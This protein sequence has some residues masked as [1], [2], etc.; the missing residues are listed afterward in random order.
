MADDERPD[1]P[2]LTLGSTAPL[3]KDALEQTHDPVEYRRR[4]VVGQLGRIPARLI[5][6]A[7][8]LAEARRAQP[9]SE[10]HLVYG[11]LEQS[12]SLVA[13]LTELTVQVSAIQDYVGERLSSD[14][15]PSIDVV[16]QADGRREI[17][18][19]GMLDAIEGRATMLAATPAGHP[20]DAIDVFVAALFDPKSLTTY[21]TAAVAGVDRQLLLEG[22]RQRLS[23]Y[24][25]VT[26]PPA[27]IVDFEPPTRI[28]WSKRDEV[29][30][31]LP[32]AATADAYWTY[33]KHE[34]EMLVYAESDA[35]LNV[36]R[37]EGLIDD[38]TAE[39]PTA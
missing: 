17:Y 9:V 24:E 2:P 5:L 29:V 36:L 11:A 21:A 1:Q 3:T 12:D 39:K 34:D 26:F 13:L 38:A 20:V 14:A 31:A 16:Q 19:Y 33:T 7:I 22:I 15:P 4:V 30:R 10:A 32:S 28:S 18:R 25:G 23:R 6:A 35:T 37:A 8:D 27:R